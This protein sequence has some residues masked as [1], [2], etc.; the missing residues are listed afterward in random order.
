[1]GELFER[2]MPH[3]A[4]PWTGERLTTG[5]TGQVEIEHLHRYAFARD[6]CRGLDVLDVASGEGYGSALVAQVARSVVGLEIDLGAVTHA[7]T[8]YKQ[9]NLRFLQGDARA[10]P[11][12][13]ASVDAVVSFETIEHFYE[14]DTF[15]AEIRRVLRSGGRLIISS[16]ERD[17]YSPVQ[18]APNPYHVRELTREEFTRLLQGAFP[19]VALYAQR[20]FLG[21]AL[22][23]E[24]PAP[25]PLLTFERRGE[26]HFEASSGLPRPLY[27]VAIASDLPVPA[28]AAA[29]YLDTPDVESVYAR[30]RAAAHEAASLQEQIQAVRG[31]AE[32]WR[33]QLLVH[34]RGLDAPLRHS[35]RMP[36]NKGH[37]LQCAGIRHHPAGES[38]IRQ[39]RAPDHVHGLA[40]HHLSAG[41]NRLRLQRREP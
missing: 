28:A 16:P 6:L 13:D 34:R 38:R 33:Q 12:A 36:R 37:P 17:I 40:A 30:L 9:P 14:H 20:A 5:I 18:S 39:R 11:L 21:A 32:N 3:S 41:K 24:D 8:A 29:L 10:I 4:L 26:T 2:A 1:M 27:W 7:Q 15:I 23:A 25:G 19:Y 35:V 31:Q 22:V